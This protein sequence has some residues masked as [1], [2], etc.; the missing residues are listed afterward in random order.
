[1]LS[2]ELFE[3]PAIVRE[4][5]EAQA[6]VEVGELRE[7]MR[8]LAVA[9]ARTQSEVTSLRD[10]FEKLRREFGSL[11]HIVGGTVEDAS[12]DALG[13]ALWRAGYKM[14]GQREA[15]QLDG[16][17]ELDA[18]VEVEGPDGHRLWAIAD[19][20]VRLRESDVRRRA[21]RIWSPAFRQRLRRFGMPGPYLPYVFG[22]TVYFDTK[23][24]EQAMREGRLQPVGVLR[25]S[26]TRIEAQVVP[27]D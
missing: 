20:K 13:G 9:Q 4:L 8:A 23:P 24:L 18:V 21:S 14:L 16:Y 27:P 26:H 17:G 22:I 10:E 25:G 15:K 11:A 5:A 7:A 1:V 2:E 19:A 12:C 3:L 6:Q